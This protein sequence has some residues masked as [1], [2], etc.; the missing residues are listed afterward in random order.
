MFPKEGNEE[1]ERML[2]EA[3]SVQVEKAIDGV[4]L[5]HSSAKSS[6]ENDIIAQDVKAFIDENLQQI[7]TSSTV[8]ATD[9][10]RSNERQN[11]P[12]SSNQSESDDRASED[13]CNQDA[14]SKKLTNAVIVDE[15]ATDT[16][17]A[18][19]IS[20]SLPRE[21]ALIELTANGISTKISN[22]TT[23]DHHSCC[24]IVSNDTLTEPSTIETSLL[25]A[26]SHNSQNIER[27]R[28]ESLQEQSSFI[29]LIP[30][31]E[32]VLDISMEGADDLV[33]ENN[34]QSLAVEGSATP[35][36]VHQAQLLQQ[37]QAEKPSATST[38]ELPAVQAS[39]EEALGCE[40]KQTCAIASESL[41]NQT[42]ISA[43]NS[44]V[45]TIEV[46]PGGAAVGTPEIPEFVETDVME[47]D[48][49]GNEVA[50]KEQQ[51]PNERPTVKPMTRSE[52]EEVGSVQV[53]LEAVH[54]GRQNSLE[55][56]SCKVDEL[57]PT[58][59]FGTPRRPAPSIDTRTITR[60]S[61]VR[62]QELPEATVT[63]F[64]KT[65]ATDMLTASNGHPLPPAPTTNAR[66]HA[67]SQS[68][69]VVGQQATVA[70][71]SQ[72]IQQSL[73]QKSLQQQ[74]VVSEPV[75]QQTSASRIIPQLEQQQQPV[76]T[77]IPMR[78]VNQP[79]VIPP[80]IT[81]SVPVNINSTV[82]SNTVVAQGPPHNPENSQKGERKSVQRVRQKTVTVQSQT[83]LDIMAA[84]N[85]VKQMNS[86]DPATELVRRVQAIVATREKEWIAKNEKLA[87]LLAHEQRR[88]EPLEQ[89]AAE[90]LLAMAEYEKLVQEFVEELKKKNSEGESKLVGRPGPER[91]LS[92]DDIA[93]LLKERDQL[94]EEVNSLETSYS[95]LFRRY[96][97]LRQTSVEI[98]RNE[99]SV[100]SASE[101]MARRYS[102]LVEK[103]EMLRRNAEE[104]LDLANNE[105]E[106]LIKQHEADTLGLRL[107]VKHQES[108]IDSLTVSLDARQKELESM[109]AIFEEV[110]TKAEA[111]GTVGDVTI[112]AFLTYFYHAYVTV[113]ILAYMLEKFLT[114]MLSLHVKY[115]S[116]HRDENVNKSSF[117]E[118]D[119]ATNVS[120]RKTSKPVGKIK[121]TNRGKIYC[122][123]WVQL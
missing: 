116:V 92:P 108:K 80:N 123:I 71:R 117:P 44:A 77:A 2:L 31:Q 37:I 86:D 60:P 15:C 36:N 90:R 8:E 13:A 105:I 20:E 75:L 41:D 73:P 65:E 84:Y 120:K 18:Q 68:S 22:E 58:T 25:A 118:P 40:V 1:V 11:P 85:E 5:N 87:Q 42:S 52:V 45:P 30:A 109:T 61:R 115:T 66:N 53:A 99:D 82:V 102:I 63:P 51:Q 47:R 10:L 113:D 12:E 89:K 81:P 112:A 26:P 23:S 101:E 69:L 67:S 79:A 16:P 98:K 29:S 33:P 46:V 49:S 96:E 6:D 7:L 78:G 24:A 54:E 70:S 4:E 111:N 74:V 103:F 50:T 17:T 76:V 21:I 122:K 72:T 28:N 59:Q 114:E 19:I 14:N 93:Q 57:K 3:L 56:A 62:A 27:F 107:K 48:S 97:K 38:S 32:E 34:A 104:Q 95:E 35:A 106:R 91:N 64:S 55:E 39:P 100:K 9:L 119:P 94:A 88:N 110:I 83:S 121:L 43:K